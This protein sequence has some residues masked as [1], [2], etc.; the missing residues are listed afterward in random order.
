MENAGGQ[1]GVGVM[2]ESDVVAVVAEGA[3]VCETVVAL[4]LGEFGN[5]KSSCLPGSPLRHGRWQQW[6]GLDEAADFFRKRL[7]YGRIRFY[8]SLRR[9]GRMYW[10]CAHRRGEEP[11]GDEG[12]ISAAGPA[13]AGSGDKPR[14][15]AGGLVRDPGH[16]CVVA[17]RVD[18]GEALAECVLLMVNE[19]RIVAVR[20][21]A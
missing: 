16:K 12:R 14:G 10:T 19:V 11:I 4:V 7:A 5:L 1:F 20:G 2:E 21:P 17:P 9:A 3:L 15:R 8:S 18:R 13:R 6:T